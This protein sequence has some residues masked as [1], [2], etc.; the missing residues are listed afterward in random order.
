MRHQERSADPPDWL[1][2]LW[3]DG[4]LAMDLRRQRVVWWDLP[5]GQDLARFRL[6]HAL[7]ARTWPGWEI[8]WAYHQMVDLKAAV[9]DEGSLERYRLVA[10]PFDGP[11]PLEPANDPVGHW[12]AHRGFTQ[13]LTVRRGGRRHRPLRQLAPAPG[14][15]GARAPSAG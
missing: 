10:D 2:D 3:A 9:G 8:A 6:V 12:W 7:M 13:L 14:L 5:A 15:V 11:V 4:G 1:D